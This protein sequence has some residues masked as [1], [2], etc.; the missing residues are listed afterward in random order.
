[1]SPN[2]R[3]AVL[4]LLV[5]VFFFLGG[6]AVLYAQGW[7]LQLNPLT[8]DK[9]GG[10]YVRTYPA[11]AAINLNGKPIPETAG[12]FERGILS[13]S[14][15]PGDYELSVSRDGYKS[16]SSN[17]AVQPSLVTSRGH[18]ILIPAKPATATS[19]V[20]GVYSLGNDVALLKAGGKIHWRGRIVDGDTPLINLGGG[21]A[22]MTKGR[23]GYYLTETGSASSTNI[24]KTFPRLN[25]LPRSTSTLLSIPGN[26]L[27]FLVWSSSTLQLANTVTGRS[28][29]LEGG[30]KDISAVAATDT[31]IAWTVYDASKKA[32]FI[33]TYDLPSNS[34]AL[35][36]DFVP[37]RT[38][39]MIWT[40][41]NSLLLLQEDGSLYS[42]APGDGSR[43]KVAKGVRTFAY[44]EREASYAFVDEDGLNVVAA[45][46]DY[47]FVRIPNPRSVSSLTWYEDGFNV[48]ISYPNMTILLN[49]EG[50]DLRN[51]LV[52]ASTPDFAYVP[53]ENNFYFLE[54]G[55]LKVLTFS[56]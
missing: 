11:D 46:R 54:N 15:F 45:G 16:W 41:R 39:K 26:G 25:L 5:L 30:V 1:M 7:R 50:P 32:S 51:D 14:L 31:R 47:V 42:M 18:L 27:S 4:S 43:I 52:V 49:V 40:G 20:V 22:I 56:E 21:Q 24:S 10:I 48:F 19:G 23:D 53:G 29:A 17:L 12:I 37:G 38:K 28:T 36:L 3:S 9:V 8:A 55:D 6:A 44:S 33:S 35:S 13:G 2:F 34:F